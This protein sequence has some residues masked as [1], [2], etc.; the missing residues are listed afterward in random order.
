M[1]EPRAH[2][3][4]VQVAVLNVRQVSWKSKEG[5]FLRLGVNRVITWAGAKIHRQRLLI[6]SFT[7]RDSR[8]V[9]RPR[10]TN[11]GFDH[12]K[13]QCLVWMLRGKPGL[14]QLN[15]LDTSCAMVSHL[16]TRCFLMPLSC[17]LL[18][19]GKWNPNLVNAATFYTNF[20]HNIINYKPES[21]N[22]STPI[23]K[24]EQLYPNI[25]AALTSNLYSPIVKFKV[26]FLN[27]YSYVLKSIWIC[28]EI[29]IDIFWA[30]HTL[31]SYYD[32]KDNF[33]KHNKMF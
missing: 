9:A 2:A 22:G 27:L 3:V 19:C 12:V 16:L 5:I 30:L 17:H 11:K 6:G 18:R 33:S 24:C 21:R 25:N 20:F 7:C 26:I 14:L 4:P 31:P 8:G 1:H 23:V 29:Y 32:L 13:Q 28:S 15:F 10:D